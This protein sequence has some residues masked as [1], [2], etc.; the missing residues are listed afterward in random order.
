M[1]RSLVLNDPL[2]E[3]SKHIAAA[4]SSALQG[5]RATHL[6]IPE[7]LSLHTKES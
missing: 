5:V 4:V 2:D 3:I 7:H 6:R 1:S